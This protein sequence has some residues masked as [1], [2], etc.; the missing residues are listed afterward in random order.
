M[1]EKV[2]SLQILPRALKS[3]ACRVLAPFYQVRN[4]IRCRK[5]W[6]VV[7]ASRFFTR[8]LV[9]QLHLNG[10]R[11]FLFDSS[12]G[13]ANW[14]FACRSKF[15]D[16]YDTRH[17]PSI[18]RTARAL[19]CNTVLMPQDDNLIPIYAEVNRLLES[20]KRFSEVAVQSSLSKGFMRKRLAEAGMDVPVW[21][22]ITNS[23]EIEG[24]SL[25]A[26]FKPLYGQ[27]SRG[28]T[29][30]ET[31]KEAHAA[32]EHILN[33]L[34]QSQCVVEEFLEGRQFDVEGVIKDG[35]PHVY[36]ITEECYT[37][38]LPNFTRPS[39]YL[40]GPDLPVDMEAEILRETH[41]ALA[42]CEFHSGAFHLELKFKG[43][44]AMT[45][46]MANRMGADFFKYMRLVTG[47]PSVLEYLKTMTTG[48]VDSRPLSSI[49]RKPILRYFNYNDHPAH[50]E[51]R[52]LAFAMERDGKA[53]LVLNGNQ[54]ELAGNERELRAFLEEVYVCRN[55]LSF[56][57][58]ENAFRKK[59]LLTT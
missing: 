55:R 59:E 42:A 22:V 44:R 32:A 14:R 57:V 2:T 49:P 47:I 12:P 31:K 1:Q 39:W 6:V 53:T 58:K 33:E 18:V 40:M 43:E 50:K 41:T 36:L 15:I 51:I 38:F 52:K 7:L 21:T 37:D 20:D 4:L 29:Y 54:L 8:E 23:D 19:G 11:V 3:I 45:I 10:Y 28:I 16:V 13:Q 25:P 17:I 9:E 48:T 27:G 46:D 30:A 35:T 34:G 5:E 56:E 26:V 24:L